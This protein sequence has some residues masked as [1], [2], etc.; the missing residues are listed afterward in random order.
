MQPVVF[1]G[2]GNDGGADGYSFGIFVE[3]TP[4]VLQPTSPIHELL[5]Q[6]AELLVSGKNEGSVLGKTEQVTLDAY[7]RRQVAVQTA[8]SRLTLRENERKAGLVLSMEL[9]F[10]AQARS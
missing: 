9:P 6:S 7:G 10:A 1:R 4:H 8:W 5:R 2:W 3:N